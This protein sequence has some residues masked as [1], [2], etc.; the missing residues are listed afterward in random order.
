[1][2]PREKRC[3]KCNGELADSPP[4]KAEFC[5]VD[6]ATM[7]V[8]GVVRSFI[9]TCPTHGRQYLQT[10]GNHATQQ[11]T[12]FEKGLTY[13]EQKRIEAA[14]TP[15]ERRFFRLACKGKAV[16]FQDQIDRWFALARPARA[17]RPEG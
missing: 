16:A 5:I 11:E 2:I 7:R 13:A 3:P 4:L 10:T 9:G 15:E 8:E 1:L 12:L 17:L 14:L 6:E